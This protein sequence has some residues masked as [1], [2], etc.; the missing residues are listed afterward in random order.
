M[1][2]RCVAE[3]TPPPES[4]RLRPASHNKDSK[5]MS[6]LFKNPYDRVG[7]LD[8]K[9]GV[10]GWKWVEM[11]ENAR[12]RSLFTEWVSPSDQNHCVAS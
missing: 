6:I 1:Q 10:N 12:R 4:T 5:T 3:L 2:G 8:E 11:G 9:G 7:G